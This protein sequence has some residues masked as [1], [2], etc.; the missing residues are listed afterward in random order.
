MWR[1]RFGCKRRDVEFR[2]SKGS[3][4]GVW[5][6]AF[7]ALKESEVLLAG[8]MLRLVSPCLKRPV[9]QR[10][11]AVQYAARSKHWLRQVSTQA[12]PTG[13]KGPLIA[14]A[15]LGGGVVAAYFLWPDVS[16]S[17][18]TY[19]NAA[20][21]PAHFTPV[22][23]T[24]S[25][26]CADPNTRLMSLTVSPDLLPPTHGSNFAP[27]WSIFIKDD[28][29]QVER[30]YTPLEGIDE[31]GT[32]KFW[33]KRYPK[34][35]VGRWLHSKSVGDTIE[36]RGPLRTWPWQE[37]TWDEVVMVS[38]PYFIAP[39]GKLT[40]IKISGGTGITPFYQLLHSVLLAPSEET[41][42]SSRT[43]FT[44]LHSS[45]VPG[46]LPPP[47]L[48]QPLV[49]YS[50][51][52]PDQ[53]RVSLFVDSKDGSS[54]QSVPNEDIRQ[55]RISKADIGSLLGDRSAELTWWQKV[56]RVST[57]KSEPVAGRKILFL[58][59]GPEP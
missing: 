11:W 14:T 23:V 55:G 58:V 53:L 5:D 3:R 18:P 38:Q 29:I 17:A 27:I 48:L 22:T 16:R 50:E 12:K 49:N 56:L 9:Q 32:M 13:R 25:E 30:P 39:T 24:A 37:N 40:D 10:T 46:E 1:W 28:D 42:P 47:E 26:Q 57:A 19:S 45:R 51:K 15:I 36:I 20:L 54:A 35:E 59:C 33:I 7:S 31:S 41:Q 44:L 8:E 4:D 2:P 6:V 34:G 21:S 43:R 52:H